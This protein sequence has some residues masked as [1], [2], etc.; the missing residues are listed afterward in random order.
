MLFNGEG[1]M[2]NVRN[3]LTSYQV[4]VDIRT[5]RS[6]SRNSVAERLG[7]FRHRA[8]HRPVCGGRSMVRATTM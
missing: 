2:F 8:M 5:G 3:S 6:I 1:E 7:K 4:R